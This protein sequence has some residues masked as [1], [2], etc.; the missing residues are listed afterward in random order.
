MST[1]RGLAAGAALDAAFGDPQRFHPVAGFGLL[2]GRAERLL[3]RPSRA[4]GAAYTVL[5]IAGALV[6]ARVA[7]GGS[8]SRRRTAGVA[9]IAWGVLGARSLGAEALRI[10]DALGRGDIGAARELLPRL[11][12]RDP[13]A[14]SEAEIV[15]ATVESVA[16]NTSDAVV[17][18]LLWGA[19]AGAPGLAGYR[20]VNTLDAMVGYRSAR[21]E[22][23]GWAAARLD[24]LA[25]V[26]PARLTALLTMAAA[27]AVGGDPRTTLRVT[28]AD[29]RNHPSPNSGWCEAAFAGALDVRLG[30]RNVYG[31]RVEDRPYLGGGR[32]PRREDIARA[33]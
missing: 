28:R 14:L 20:A 10:D 21:Y 25:N 24:D 8:H 3:W 32:A 4:A 13:A 33:V 1:P 2:A 23:F 29:G 26:V 18:P 6:A 5:C 31:D 16:E 27:P 30:G 11:C 19:L 12:G 17:A 22:T 9:A 7:A 15:R